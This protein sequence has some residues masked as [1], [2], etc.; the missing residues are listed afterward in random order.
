MLKSSC[1]PIWVVV[2]WLTFV[3]SSLFA[4]AYINNEQHKKEKQQ[5]EQF[6]K[7]KD[8]NGLIKVVKDGEIRSKE[9]AAKWLGEFGD[10]SAIPVLEEMNKFYAN[11]ECYSSGEFAVAICKIKNKGRTNK[12]KINALIE[13]AK[14]K[15]GSISSAAAIEISRF[16]DPVV[17]SAL[18]ELRKLDGY[19]AVQAV[20]KLES[21]NLTREE[22]MPKYIQILKEHKTPMLAEGAEN[23]LI[24]IGEPAISN[25]IELLIGL[26]AG[27]TEMLR[28]SFSITA[29][30]M[31]R[32]IRILEKISNNK[33][34][35]AIGERV[36]DHNL[37]VKSYAIIAL[38]RI[39]GE[40]FG[41]DYDDLRMGED[42]FQKALQGIAKAQEWW[43][44]NKYRF[45]EKK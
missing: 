17:L 21:F 30:V 4:E 43:S 28:E 15:T 25:T 44:K 18:P 11:F 39:T 22:K 9:I 34:I 42:K 27:H 3:T 31:T 10:Q 2:I 1:L 41:F 6:V 26:D 5:I 35:L 12:E 29:T 16:Q 19:G 20:I 23:L 38:Q 13:L 36:Y 33:C 8:I 32:C 7:G 37:Y 45:E 40:N 14:S 24:E